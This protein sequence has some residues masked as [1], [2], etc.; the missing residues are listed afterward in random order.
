MEKEE[1]LLEKFKIAIT[2][3]IKSISNDEKVEVVFGSSVKTTNS[4]TIRLSEIVSTNNKINHVKIRAQADAEALKIRYSNKEILK[5]NAPEGKIS[6]QLYNIAEKIRC[7]KIGSIEFQGTKRNISEYYKERIENMDFNNN[8]DSTIEAF[9][10]YLRLNILNY[11]NNKNIEKNLEKFKNKFQSKIEA[12]IYTLKNS[13]NNQAKFNEIISDLIINMN[14]EEN[15]E[16][17]HT[18]QHENENEKQE[19]K[20][21]DNEKKQKGKS[22]ENQE[23]SIEAGMPDVESY[24]EESDNEAESLEIENS[25][26]SQNQRDNKDLNFGDKK[27]K[28]FTEEFDEVIKAE[29]LENE[30]ELNRLRQSLDQQ[31]S[32]LKNF[33]SKLANKLQRNF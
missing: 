14:I 29:E 27:Y 26:D 2:S 9:E 19:N 23:M 13:F 20:P 12:Q 30:E 11:K 4:E 16:S 24:T 5:N 22:D 3:T 17:S 31:L 1:D 21:Q 7:E 18:D 28:V 33:I 15:F 25:S 32:Q 6:K 10:H 8:R